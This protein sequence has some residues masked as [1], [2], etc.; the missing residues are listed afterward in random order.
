[1]SVVVTILCDNTISQSGIIGE[2]G[3][4]LLLERGEEKV[5]F[6]TGPG[7]SLP[8]NLKALGKNLTALE[9]FSSATV[10]MITREGSSG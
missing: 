5:L 7:M 4:S 3:F 10:I 6:D 9:R 2:H 1:M 8:L